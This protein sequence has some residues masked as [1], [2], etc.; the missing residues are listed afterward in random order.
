MEKIFRWIRKKYR[1]YAAAK[2]KYVFVKELPEIVPENKVI[3]VSEDGM[4][5]SL[6]FRCPCGC[7]TDIFLNLLKD[8]KPIWRF[9]ISKKNKITITPSIWRKVGCKSHFFIRKGKIEWA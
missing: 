1:F 9:H 8:A 2:Y 5:D 6:V 7:H 3:I 4:P